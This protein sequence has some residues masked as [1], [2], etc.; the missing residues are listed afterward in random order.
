MKKLINFANNIR[1]SEDLA[2]S[3]LYLAALAAASLFFIFFI[4]RLTFECYDYIKINE[5]KDFQEFIVGNY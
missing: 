3:L 5:F 2:I 1:K 4:D